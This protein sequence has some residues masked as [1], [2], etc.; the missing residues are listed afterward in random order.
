MHPERKEKGVSYP[1]RVGKLYHAPADQS[2]RHTEV[3]PSN[4]EGRSSN[5][6]NDDE[7]RLARQI[8]EN[9]QLA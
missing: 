8:L 9:S 5:K 4:K 6:K 7:K 3:H 2:K 1:S